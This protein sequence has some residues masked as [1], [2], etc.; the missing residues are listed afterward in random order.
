M[1]IAPTRMHPFAGPIAG[2]P[3][4]AGTGLTALDVIYAGNLGGP[5][6]ALGGSCGNVLISLAMLGHSVAPVIS[7]GADSHGDFLV[8][9]LRHAGCETRFVFRASIEGSPVIVEHI[10]VG[11]AQ[12]WFSLSCPG[13][14]QSFPRWRSIDENQVRSARAALEEISVFYTDRLSPAIVSAMEAAHGAG[15]L[16]VFE[17]ASRGDDDNLFARALKTVS[18]LK[19]SGDTTGQYDIAC[20]ETLAMVVIRT[21]G[22][23]GLTATFQGTEKFFP[24]TAAPRLV[25]TCGSGD[26]VTTGLLDYLLTHWR[27]S[28][29]W[30]AADI[31]AGVEAGQQLAAINCAFAGARGI[32]HAL[33][34][35][36]VRSALD[37]GFS[38]DFIAYAMKFGPCDGYLDYS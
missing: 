14:D 38:K 34:A 3:V 33:G 35:R 12:H 11:R 10:D 15:A 7:I 19:I 25:D 26:M 31:Y 8:D 24:P 9:A 16:V 1:R 21:H 5:L 28:S 32:F 18:I 17:P 37:H 22:S 36:S 29:R 30:L 20:E 13:T 27:E 4:V 2:R 23:K 6:K